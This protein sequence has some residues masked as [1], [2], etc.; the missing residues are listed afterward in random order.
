MC[1][2][3][4]HRGN[5]RRISQEENAGLNFVFTPKDFARL[6]KPYSRHMAEAFLLLIGRYGGRGA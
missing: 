4:K 1:E 2:G 5:T 6:R 3:L